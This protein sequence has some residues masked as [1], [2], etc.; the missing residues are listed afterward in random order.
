MTRAYERTSRFRANPFFCC[1]IK[2]LVKKSVLRAKLRSVCCPVRVHYGPRSPSIWAIVVQPQPSAPRAQIRWPAATQRRELD[3]EAAL[4]QNEGRRVP[5]VVE[6]FVI[7]A[8]KS[9]K[10]RTRSS[11]P[12]RKGVL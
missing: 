4:H 10:R 5:D 9:S 3:R 8:S 11:A 2:A 6:R 7:S 1:P 12:T